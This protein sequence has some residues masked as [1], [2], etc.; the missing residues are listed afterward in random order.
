MCANFVFLIN[1]NS[2][3][4]SDGLLTNMLTFQK[5]FIYKMFG[6]PCKLESDR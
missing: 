3:F 1:C 4:F 5:L 2:N 6:N